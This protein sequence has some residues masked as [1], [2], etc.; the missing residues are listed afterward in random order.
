MQNGS[1]LAHRLNGWAE[2]MRKL[3]IALCIP[4]LAYLI[5]PYIALIKLYIGL[6]SANKKIV[7]EEILWPL[8]RKGIE[9][10]LNRFV[11]EVLNKNLKQQ[12]IQISFSAISLTRQIADEIATPEGIIY[13]Y[14]NPNK[15]ADQI[16]KIFKKVSESKQLSP[17]IKEKPLKLE[18]PI[19]LEGP[20]VPSLWERID[21]IFFIDFSHFKASFKI[22]NQSFTIIWKRQGFDWKVVLLNFP[23][24]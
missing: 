15:Y 11:K 24:A 7:Q 20:N 16:R 19:K 8:I 6:E 1:E 17:P 9:K 2:N 18:G 13:L 5:W 14:H 12:N 3:S 22:K 23:L 4:V 10:D 21:Y